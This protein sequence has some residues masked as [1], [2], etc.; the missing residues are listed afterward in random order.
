MSS[1]TARKPASWENC[2]WWPSTIKHKVEGVCLHETTAQQQRHLCLSELINHTI[3]TVLPTPHPQLYS[4]PGH[5]CTKISSPVMCHEPDL[6]A[7]DGRSTGHLSAFCLVRS[8]R[9]QIPVFLSV[10]DRADGDVPRSGNTTQEVIMTDDGQ[11]PQFAVT[12]KFTPF[13]F[14]HFSSESPLLLLRFSPQTCT[15]VMAPAFSLHRSLQLPEVFLFSCFFEET[16]MHDARTSRWHRQ[17]S[18]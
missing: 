11:W 16:C 12:I 15:A 10:R 1:S 13:V 17:A 4:R 18:Y 8:L 3:P 6:C 14:T 9:I 7:S 2:W 5:C